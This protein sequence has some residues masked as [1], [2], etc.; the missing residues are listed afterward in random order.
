MK[1]LERYINKIIWKL[2]HGLI[3]KQTYHLLPKISEVYANNEVGKMD[4]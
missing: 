2:M 4:I 1:A 3:S